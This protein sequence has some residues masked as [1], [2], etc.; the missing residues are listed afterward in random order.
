MKQSLFTKMHLL[1][2]LKDAGEPCSYS[3]LLYY[4]KLGVVKKPTRSIPM[5]D[6]S[7]RAYTQAEIDRTVSKIK[8][9]RSRNTT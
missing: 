3:S 8:K 2:A 1:Q 7:Y 9:Y 6:R 4:E 5:G